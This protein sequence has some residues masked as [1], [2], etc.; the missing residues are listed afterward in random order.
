MKLVQKFVLYSVLWGAAPLW[1]QGTGD[2]VPPLPDG[3]LAGIW[4]AQLGD[5][6]SW[7]D[8]GLDDSAW[9]PVEVPGRWRIDDLRTGREGDLGSAGEGTMVWL[10]RTLGA[11][12]LVTPPDRQQPMAVSLGAVESSYELYLNGLRIGGAG[13]MPPNPAPAF[14]RWALHP[15]PPEAVGPS[16]RWTLAIRIW[17]GPSASPAAAGPVAGPF[18]VGLAEELARSSLR[19]QL[20]QLILTALFAFLALYHLQLLRHSRSHPW[21][22]LWIGLL[23]LNAALAVFFQSQ[24]RFLVPASFVALKKAG[25]FSLFLLPAAWIQAFWP[26]LGRPLSVP[27]RVYQ[28]AHMGLA[29]L[30][31]ALPGLS[32]GR[33]V[34]TWWDLWVLPLIVLSAVAMIRRSS[35]ER[36]E[37]VILSLGLAGIS[38]AVLHDGALGR[39]WLSGGEWLH[40]G[41]GLFLFG[42]ALVL[43]DR[44]S[45]VYHELEDLR[46][47]LR[48]RIEDRTRELSRANARLQELDRSKS[49]FLAN[50]SHE[51]R[52]PMNGIIGMSELLLKTDLD[53]VQREYASTIA[54]SGTSLLSLIDDILDFSKIEAGKLTLQDADFH[55]GSTVDSVIELLGP[56]ARDK[57]IEL[58]LEMDSSLPKRFRGDAARLRQVLMN[59]I[60]NA[61]KFTEF[62][63]VLLRIEKANFDGQR[64]FVRFAVADTGVGIDESQQKNL[65]RSFTQVDSSSARR[66]GGT[67][68]GLAISKNIVELMSGQIG[69]RSKLGEGSVFYF[70]I[71]LAPPRQS[72]TE[73]MKAELGDDPD[74]RQRSKFRILVAEDN[75]INQMVTLRQLRAL[76]FRAEAVANG[77]DVL[78]ALGRKRFDLILMDCQMP[79]LDGYET[80]RRIRRGQ[81]SSQ[82]IPIVAVTAHAMKG[83]RE[84]CL[85]SGMDDYLA[86][87]FREQDLSSLL[88]RWLLSP[89]GEAAAERP[90]DPRQ[91]PASPETPVPLTPL[92]DSPL[93]RTPVAGTPAPEPPD[94]RAAEA[95][96][97]AL[98]SKSIEGLRKLGASSGEDVLEKVSNLFLNEVP[99]RLRRIRRAAGEGDRET[100][101]HT[102]H[103]LKGSAGILGAQAF[104]KRSQALELAARSNK[105]EDQDVLIERLEEEYAKVARELKRLLVTS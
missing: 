9:T 43:S 83:D 93:P 69:L 20:P 11:R 1:G 62:G 57:N 79:N 87:P 42:L 102:A 98:D 19:R 65:F 94:R 59:L 41:L 15:I 76:G 2:A 84:R 46:R 52:T 13:A 32:F 88:D 56:R 86:K 85:A 61:I 82:R 48:Q 78:D 64:L 58:K 70:T 38:V 95:V 73:A 51:I 100:L 104:L 105:L 80:T 44:F 92:P 23:A 74:L 34:A 39:Q 40:F 6:P 101:E 81:G 16:A 3:R 99:E 68:L 55:L 12:T 35:T 4:K 28:L 5:D 18:A 49:E 7:S 24:W 91:S 29:F 96:P 47:G 75:P 14:D 37:T 8:P 60:G 25:L 53:L 10:R 63:R 77:I 21:T 17:Q 54:S 26:I 71:P 72:T 30:A 31:V 66:F 90:E 89:P 67:G 97:A 36:L 45:R 103:S 50:M 22:Y 33:T 27:L